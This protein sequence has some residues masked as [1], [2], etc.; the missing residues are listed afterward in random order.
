MGTSL[1]LI[2]SGIVRTVSS[3]SEWLLAH[4]FPPLLEYITVTPSLQDT[5]VAIP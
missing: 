4:V 5:G 2:A 3:H 1:K